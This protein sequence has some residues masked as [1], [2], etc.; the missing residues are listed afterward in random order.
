MTDSTITVDTIYGVSTFGSIGLHSCE[1]DVPD[2]A[3]GHNPHY[4]D[5]KSNSLYDARP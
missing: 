2:G 1:Q 4:Q 5:M 3:L